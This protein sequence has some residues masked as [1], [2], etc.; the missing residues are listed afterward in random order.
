MSKYK[1]TTYVK[2]PILTTVEAKNK[3]EAIFL[4]WQDARDG[5]GEYLYEAIGWY[6]DEIVAREIG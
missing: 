1:V 4:G 5:K 3:D 6:T 2:I